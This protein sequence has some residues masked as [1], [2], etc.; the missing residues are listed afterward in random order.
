LPDA[1]EPQR[2]ARSQA[3]ISSPESFVAA[4]GAA[5]QVRAA[6]A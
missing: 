5:T 3:V 6:Q 4:T 1:S 2:Q